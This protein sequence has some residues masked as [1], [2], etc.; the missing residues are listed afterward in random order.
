MLIKKIKGDVMKW[1]DENIECVKRLIAEGYT[2]KDIAKKMGISANALNRAMYKYGLSKKQL[3]N[4]GEKMILNS[5]EIKRRHHEA[6]HSHKV[7]RRLL[8]GKNT[9]SAINTTDLRTKEEKIK[10]RIVKE[11][12]YFYLV[13]NGNY[14]QTVLKNSLVNGDIKVIGCN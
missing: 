14:I 8:R 2:R 3:K 1:N 7:M 11:Y 6:V 4:K 10:G 12:D 9:V 5:A 13:D